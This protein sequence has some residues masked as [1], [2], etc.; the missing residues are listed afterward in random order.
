MRLRSPDPHRPSNGSGGLNLVDDVSSDGGGEDS[1]RGLTKTTSA[2]WLPPLTPHGGPGPAGAKK[3]ASSSHRGWGDIGDGEVAE[4]L[5]SARQIAQQAGDDDDGWQAIGRGAVGKAAAFS[6]P[7]ATFSS[8][9]RKPADSSNSHDDATEVIVDSLAA[10]EA[11][12]ASNDS[13]SG[14]KRSAAKTASL[15]AAFGVD[16][17]LDP[18]S[19]PLPPPDPLF[20][21]HRNILQAAFAMGAIVLLFTLVPLGSPSTSTFID[22]LPFA[23]AVWGASAAVLSVMFGEQVQYGCVWWVFGGS[24]TTH[25]TG[26]H[27]QVAML[28]ESSLT[29]SLLA[30]PALLLASGAGLAASLAGWAPT[31]WL[32]RSPRFASGGGHSVLTRMCLSPIHSLPA[33][34]QRSW[35]QC[36][37]AACSRLRTAVGFVGCVPARSRLLPAC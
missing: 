13:L 10:N 31:A 1:K 37:C 32:V 21:F 27:I 7:P 12:L 30:L 35:L 23:V 15:R 17:V 24:W 34:W 6:A 4:L 16:E 2:A 14:S 8:S 3:A 33:R 28:T 5:E 22:A 25:L 20:N 29:G 18:S 26:C 9:A 36:L 19:A 11:V